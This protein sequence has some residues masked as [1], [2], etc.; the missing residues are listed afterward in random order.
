MIY[1]YKTFK[2]KLSRAKVANLPPSVFIHNQ[3][4]LDEK[5]IKEIQ[6]QMDYDYYIK[7]IYE[8]IE[9]FIDME[10]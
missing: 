1:K 4:I 9:T 8:K 5:A 10:D 3:S 2:G 7:R 6:S